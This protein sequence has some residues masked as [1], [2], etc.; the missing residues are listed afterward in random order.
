ME[1]Q[2]AKKV[3]PLWLLSLS[4]VGMPA[5]WGVAQEASRSGAREYG[6]TE[7]AET[8]RAQAGSFESLKGFRFRGE[9]WQVTEA[10]ESRPEANAELLKLASEIY[11]AA[12]EDLTRGRA[13]DPEAA[14]MWSEKM[15]HGGNPRDAAQGHHQRMVQLAEVVTRRHERGEASSYALLAARYYVK[16]AAERV[17]Q[18]KQTGADLGSINPS[19]APALSGAIVSHNLTLKSLLRDDVV[20]VIP[21]LSTSK[22]V[23]IAQTEEPSVIQL[24]GP[25]SVLEQTVLALERLDTAVGQL[26]RGDFVPPVSPGKDITGVNHIL[27]APVTGLVASD[28]IKLVPL[29]PGGEGV[30]AAVSEDA[31]GREGVLLSGKARTVHQISS[32]ILQVV[33]K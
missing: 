12:I 21:E 2:M 31:L 18:S 27:V 26:K 19:D 17:E 25:M 16:Q 24:I 8:E 28:V 7:Y 14:Y 5:A 20:K 32:V 13:N 1:N 30:T 3:L 11:A 9:S 10:T 23:R 29:I 22:Q 15:A 4:I 33:K 6:N